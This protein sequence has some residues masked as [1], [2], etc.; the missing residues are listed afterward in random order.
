MTF[1]IGA[2]IHHK[3]G[4]SSIDKA[5]IITPIHT[6]LLYPHLTTPTGLNL[7]GLPE[8]EYRLVP[9]SGRVLRAGTEVHA[10]RR[11]FKTD[12]KIPNKTL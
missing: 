10:I 9:V 2:L 7:Y 3:L 8:E 5:E 4:H 12:I 1:S 6:G 11:D